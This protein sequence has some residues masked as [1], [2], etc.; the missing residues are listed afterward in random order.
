MYGSGDPIN[1]RDRTGLDDDG[2]DETGGGSCWDD[3]SQSWQYCDA[4]ATQSAGAGVPDGSC[5][6]RQTS[7]FNDSLGQ[8][9][10]CPGYTYT[11]DGEISLLMGLSPDNLGD[12]GLVESY[13]RQHLGL[14][15]GGLQEGL[16][17]HN[18][19]G[20]PDSLQQVCT[21]L[22]TARYV[23]A[24][25]TLISA[26]MFIFDPEPGGKL[27]GAGSGVVLGALYLSLTL[28]HNSYCGNGN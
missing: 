15:P 9:A 22:Q 24:V 26:G 2:T 28:F 10:Y 25:G 23:A 13:L 1:R 17:S 7:Y 21:A 11:N 16:Q 4:L 19:Y 6:P 12:G 20:R 27:V 3:A 5:A 8:W 14:S 18:G